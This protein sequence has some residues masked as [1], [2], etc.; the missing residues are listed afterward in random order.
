MKFTPLEIEILKHR[1]EVPDCIAEALGDYHPEDVDAV[2]WLLITHLDRGE[3]PP[4]PPGQL[5]CDVLAEAVEGSTYCATLFDG[6]QG[7]AKYRA[8]C[9][10]A[11]ALA[12]KV[13]AIIG[14]DVAAMTC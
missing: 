12:K 9:R 8:A 7:K 3:W 13:S 10:A 6:E 4:E 5:E 2:C 11:E 14:R 1:L